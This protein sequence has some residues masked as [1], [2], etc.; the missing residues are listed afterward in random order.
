MS[1]GIHYISIVFFKSTVAPGALE[2]SKAE[3]A[4]ITLLTFREKVPLVSHPSSQF[5][6]CLVI[7]MDQ[8]NFCICSFIQRFV[9]KPHNWPLQPRREARMHTTELQEW[10]FYSFIWGVPFTPGHSECGFTCVSQ[11]FPASKCNVIQLLLNTHNPL[12]RTCIS[13][14]TSSTCFSTELDIPAV[15]LAV[16]TSPGC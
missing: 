10:P 2:S 14:A 11:R 1:D 16:I 15:R 4:T 7:L 6:N 12:Q 9:K 13:M 3:P 8:K 5:C